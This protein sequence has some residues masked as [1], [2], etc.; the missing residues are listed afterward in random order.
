MLFNR[1]LAMLAS[2]FTCSTDV[3]VHLRLKRERKFFMKVI[4]ML[5][6]MLHRLQ[7]YSCSCCFSVNFM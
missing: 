1:H 4:N 7:Y 3:L 5:Q 2:K 6:I